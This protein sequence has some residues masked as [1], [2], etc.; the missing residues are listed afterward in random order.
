MSGQPEQPKHV[1]TND[2]AS[3]AAMSADA[4]LDALIAGGWEPCRLLK[5]DGSSAYFEQ[6][7]PAPYDRVR[8]V[9]LIE[10]R[11]VWRIPERHTELTEA[12]KR[13]GMALAAS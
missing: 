8:D 1:A 12:M 11:Q 4:F 5:R 10:M 7:L 3:I 2:A 13:R 9:M 6:P